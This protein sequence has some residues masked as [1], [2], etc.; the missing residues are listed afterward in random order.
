[1]TEYCN[2]LHKLVVTSN[3]VQQKIPFCCI[4][5]RHNKSLLRLPA[6]CLHGEPPASAVIQFGLVSLFRL[7]FRN[8]VISNRNRNPQL[9]NKTERNETKQRRVRGCYTSFPVEVCRRF[10]GTYSILL[11]LY[12]VA[13]DWGRMFLQNVGKLVLTYTALHIRR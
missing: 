12:F 3:D 1:V 8:T 13:E 7:A 10:E 9:D 2:A 6:I 5:P 4:A 11:G